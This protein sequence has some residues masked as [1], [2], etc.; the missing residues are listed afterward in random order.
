MVA[1]E[2]RVLLLEGGVAAPPPPRN[3]DHMHSGMRERVGVFILSQ[4]H[5]E[6]CLEPLT[7]VFFFIGGKKYIKSFSQAL[8]FAPNLQSCSSL[9]SGG[10]DAA[11][12]N[13]NIRVMAEDLNCAS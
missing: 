11:A 6:T 7:T 1:S 5:D 2:L 8:F 10:G 12:A 3:W 13:E 9:E 4:G